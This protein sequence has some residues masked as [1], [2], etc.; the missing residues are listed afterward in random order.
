LRRRTPAASGR[1]NASPLPHGASGR[2]RSTPTPMPVPRWPGRRNTLRFARRPRLRSR[3]TRMV[4]GRAIEF[5][6]DTTKKQPVPVVATMPNAASARDQCCARARPFGVAAGLG[7]HLRE[8]LRRSNGS[9]RPLDP[10]RSSTYPPG[11]KSAAQ[12][13]GVWHQA[14]FAVRMHAASQSRVRAE[15]LIRRNR[16]RGANAPSTNRRNHRIVSG[17]RWRRSGHQRV[18]FHEPSRLRI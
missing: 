4:A 1:G 8:G 13:W 9:R 18:M 16:V 17:K 11:A 2:G 12:R 6:F 7:R 14:A 15:L 3:R 10:S 5:I